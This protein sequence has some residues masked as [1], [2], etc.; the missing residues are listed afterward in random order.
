MYNFGGVYMSTLAGM[1][2]GTISPLD[3]HKHT[4]GI[5][6]QTEYEL[7]ESLPTGEIK[8]YT[9]GEIKITYHSRSGKKYTFNLKGRY[10]SIELEED[11][12]FI[13]EVEAYHNLLV[14]RGFSI[15][16]GVIYNMEEIEKKE[17]SARNSDR[18]DKMRQEKPR[19]NR[20]G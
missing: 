13:E 3:A 8:E 11:S 7:G 15:Y 9:D 12:S 20:R 17:W 6:A 2:K 14:E 5:I 19:I 18:Y 10:A 1:L 16:E 4:L